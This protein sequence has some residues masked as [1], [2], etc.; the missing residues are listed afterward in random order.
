MVAAEYSPPSSPCT[1]GVS[2]SPGFT[3]FDQNITA[4]EQLVVFNND[5]IYKPEIQTVYA[6]EELEK[7]INL[8]FHNIGHAAIEAVN[9]NASG[10]GEISLIDSEEGQNTLTDIETTNEGSGVENTDILGDD[11]SQ[12][13]TQNRIN[14]LAKNIVKMVITEEL[15]TSEISKIELVK[16]TDEITEINEELEAE[17][18]EECQEIQALEMDENKI[19]KYIEELRNEIK[20]KIASILNSIFDAEN[21]EELNGAEIADKLEPQAK[22]D[23]AKQIIDKLKIYDKIHKNDIGII[24][25][26][27]ANSVQLSR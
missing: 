6:H 27:I 18:P 1:E 2:D 22:G 11:E 3:E 16:L 17:P 26:E 25:S 8:S 13:R 14:K 4:S 20:Q 23:I 21:N 19:E 7:D 15:D 5:A 12:E 24:T 9:F 10:N